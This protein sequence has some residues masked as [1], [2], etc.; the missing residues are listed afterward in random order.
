MKNTNFMIENYN[1]EVKKTTSKSNQ[2]I[3]LDMD[4]TR[5]KW[6]T[7]LLKNAERSYTIEPSNNIIQSMYRPFVKKIFTI[8]GIYLKD[9]VDLNIFLVK[10]TSLL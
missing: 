4:Q 10:K 5:I 7:D 6:S 9:Q 3:D 2:I 1:N 8:K